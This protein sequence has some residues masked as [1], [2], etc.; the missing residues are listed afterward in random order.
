MARN[1]LAV[2][3]KED[4][5]LGPAKIY[6]SALIT[7]VIKLGNLRE[8]NG[9][10]LDF[11][12]GVGHLKKL[13]PGKNIIGYDI[14]PELSDVSDYKNLKPNKIVLISVL[15]HLHLNE[16]DKLLQEFLAMNP[17]ADL[18]VLLPTENF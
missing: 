3:Y 10:I 12:C 17:Q 18:I 6:H 1:T 9:L 15:E 13:L 14:I 4:Y 8:E 11:G 7:A 16:I 2:D 5:W